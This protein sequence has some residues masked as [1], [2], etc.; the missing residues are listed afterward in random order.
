M[1]RGQRTSRP[2][3]FVR[4]VILCGLVF[5]PVAA[6]FGGTLAGAMTFAFWLM[7]FAIPF[8]WAFNHLVC[9]L[10]FSNND[11]LWKFKRLGGDIF[12]DGVLPWPINPDDRTLRLT[13]IR[14]PKISQRETPPT[15]SHQCQHCGARLPEPGGIC[16]HC[17]NDFDGSDQSTWRFRCPTCSARNPEKYCVCWNCHADYSRPQ[18][19]DN[20]RNNVKR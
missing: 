11:E 8:F 2:V 15:W 18:T 13:G 19:A 3:M 16:W 1:N 5:W 10:L 14:E 7:V 17:G 4:A 20:T 6:M 12:F 9:W